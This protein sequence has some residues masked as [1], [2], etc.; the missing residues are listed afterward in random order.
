MKKKL[1]GPTLRRL[2]RY[3]R[4]VCEHFE[5][6]EEYIRSVEIARRL[7]VDETQVRKDIAAINYSGKPKIGFNTK[8]FKAHLESFL[9]LSNA[10]KAFLIGAGSLGLALAKYTGFNKYGLDIIALF[11]VDPH[12]IGLKIA[13][14]EIF[15]ISEFTEK[16]CE[17]DI[18]IVIIAIP[19]EEAQKMATLAVNSGIKAIWNFAPINIEVPKEIIVA[20]QDIAADFVIL[21]M[22]IDENKG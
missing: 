22:K 9:D 5:R 13:E 12:K 16:V 10:K 8:E 2:P 20:N 1:S 19:G 11:D 15:H 21:S 14:K 6:G 17:Q 3:Y 4:I 7:D 18:K